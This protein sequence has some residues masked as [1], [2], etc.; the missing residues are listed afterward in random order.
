MASRPSCTYS[1]GLRWATAAVNHD[2]DVPDAVSGSGGV[3]IEELVRCPGWL[4]AP[5]G[6]RAAQGL[7]LLILHGSRARPTKLS[8]TN[9][10]R[11]PSGGWGQRT[12]N[13]SLK[14]NAFS[15]A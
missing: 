10:A 12:K 14:T 15:N 3:R 4:A 1:S 7:A 11:S 13:H 5:I 8:D 9:A 2:R 6:F